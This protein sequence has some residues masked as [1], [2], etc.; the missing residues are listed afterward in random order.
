MLSDDELKE[1]MKFV[2]F[3]SRFHFIIN[4]N[5]EIAPGEFGTEYLLL[6]GDDASG[7]PFATTAGRFWAK[8]M[9]FVE[10]GEDKYSEL[11]KINERISL[12]FRKKTPPPK[13]PGDWREI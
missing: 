11:P 2:L 10:A 6:Y 13:P 9:D 3:K 1:R 4:E 8:F 7:L 12:Y 5:Q